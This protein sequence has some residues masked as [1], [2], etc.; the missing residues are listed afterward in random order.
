MRRHLAVAAAVALVAVSL[1][2]AEAATRKPAPKHGSYTL[3]LLPDPTPNATN[4]VGMDGCSGVSP[5]GK[6]R[7]TLTIPARG[8]L[9]VVLDSPDPTGSGVTDWDLYLVQPD[10]Q[11]YDSSHG[12]T[13]HEEI[14]TKF[15]HAQ[16][17]FVDAC[18]LAGQPSGTVTWVFTYA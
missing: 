11:V 7:H 16:K 6:D 14:V 1:T 2:S 18:N 13:S 8:T 3:T 10:G 12:G 17:M 5:A 15:K 9:K 4:V